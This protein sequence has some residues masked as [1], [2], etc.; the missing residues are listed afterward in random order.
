M[1]NQ[2]QKRT[3][4]YIIRTWIVGV[5]LVVINLFGVTIVFADT[6]LVEGNCTPLQTIA[7]IPGT[8][9]DYDGDGRLGAAEDTDDDNVF[10]TISAALNGRGNVTVVTSGTFAEAIAIPTNPNLVGSLTLQAAPG[11]EASLDAVVRGADN[12]A[13]QASN[14]ITVNAPNG[15][16]IIIRN[17]TL[18]RWDGGIRVRGNSRVA[19]EDC[20]VE[21]NNFFGIRAED[22][23]KVTITNTK[24]HVTSTDNDS[25]LGPSPTYGIVFLGRSSGSI[26]SSTVSGTFVGI[27]NLTG[28]SSAVCA[29]NVNV[30]D[31]IR[32]FENVTPSPVPCGSP[33][34]KGRTFS[35]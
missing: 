25:G 24:V 17:L 32:N 28:M 16:Y 13:R 3:A 12:T 35:R 21:N 9:G 23:V 18:R 22:N 6:A 7:A 33:V 15:A 20:R 27:G 4:E 29:Y 11:V 10:G 26:F 14:G 2:I 34:V 8:C 31:N 1:T 19:I 30:F 5:V